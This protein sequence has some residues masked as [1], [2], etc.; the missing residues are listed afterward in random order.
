MIP[1]TWKRQNTFITRWRMIIMALLV[2][3]LSGYP[4]PLPGVAMQYS[5]LGIVIVGLLATVFITYLNRRYA[6]S[7]LRVLEMDFDDTEFAVRKILKDKHIR[8]Q[9]QM[10]EEITHF[11]LTGYDISMRVEPYTEH[12]LEFSNAENPPPAT[13]IIINGLNG[14]DRMLTESLMTAIDEIV[15]HEP[16]ASS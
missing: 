4:I 15:I 7:L 6:N 11:E 14:K 3:L 9:R 1:S 2:V 5:G 12:V 13:S 8:F 10:E 16:L